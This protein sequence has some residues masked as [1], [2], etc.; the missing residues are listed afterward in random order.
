MEN[1]AD[2]WYNHVSAAYYRSYLHTTDGQAFMPQTREESHSLLNAFLLEK[3]VYELGYEL[4]HRPR[5]VAIPLL[6]VLKLLGH[7]DG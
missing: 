1:W 5:W 6:G 2:F 7:A 3:A 4:N